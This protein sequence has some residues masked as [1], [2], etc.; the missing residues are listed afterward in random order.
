MNSEVHFTKV[1]MLNLI[2]VLQQSILQN[3]RLWLTYT[4]WVSF[5][6]LLCLEKVRQIPISA[7]IPWTK[8]IV[9]SRLLVFVLV[10]LEMLLENYISGVCERNIS[11]KIIILPEA[12]RLRVMLFIFLRDIF[13]SNCQ[14]CSVSFYYP[15]LGIWR[16]RNTLENGI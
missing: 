14:K 5:L 4:V 9:I 15:I 11:Q 7:T 16:T 10:F 6:V 2:P 13:L 3:I 1:L 8:A 12:V